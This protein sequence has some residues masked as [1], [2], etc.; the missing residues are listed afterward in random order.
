MGDFWLIWTI[1]FNKTNNKWS[2]LTSQP[3]GEEGNGQWEIT[4]NETF[5]IYTYHSN[6]INDETTP[7][8]PPYIDVDDTPNIG[9]EYRVW[10]SVNTSEIKSKPFIVDII[11]KKGDDLWKQT[12][13][14][15]WEM[16]EANNVFISSCPQPPSDYNSVLDSSDQSGTY[17]TYKSEWT[18]IDNSLF[19]VSGPDYMG[20][21]PEQGSGEWGLT[22]SRTDPILGKVYQ[23]YWTSSVKGLLQV[24]KYT[25][26]SDEELEELLGLCFDGNEDEIIVEK[27]SI[28]SG[29]NNQG[30]SSELKTPTFRCVYR[31][32]GKV[33]DEVEMIDVTPVSLDNVDR[34]NNW[35]YVDS[36]LYEDDINCV[37]YFYST[38]QN[39]DPDLFKY[40]Q[41][42]DIDISR[43]NC[44]D[45]SSTGG[46][47]I[48]SL[49][50]VD[51]FDFS[52][53]GIIGVYSEI[54][55]D[56]LLNRDEGLEWSYHADDI[57]SIDSID[58]VDSSEDS[59]D[60]DGEAVEGE[61]VDDDM[62]VVVES[63]T[64]V[65]D[66]DLSSFILNARFSTEGGI[67]SINETINYPKYFISQ[68][69]SISTLPVTYVAGSVSEICSVGFSGTVIELK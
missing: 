53:S 16:V 13:A 14:F 34:D 22:D 69:I 58:S 44:V 55:G 39:K 62:N 57:E 17:R 51:L 27:G 32:D 43:C 47:K 41:S 35:K 12:T 37:Y 59:S 46:L 4:N 18:C 28:P 40:P 15:E 50:D 5:I 10:R 25:F 8:L 49:Y 56:Y 61:E 45:I 64:L 38:E 24:P 19:H 67:V 21:I 31:C 29:S 36:Y 9:M 52:I 48:D 1:N 68:S 65:Y 33:F 6:I 23:L 11:N 26:P 66:E 60:S 30:D 42:D 63:L 20:S 3:S 54:N 7:D 2:D